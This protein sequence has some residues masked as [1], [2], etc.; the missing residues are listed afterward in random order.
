MVGKGQALFDAEPHFPSD[1][2]IRQAFILHTPMGVNLV[3][4]LQW[5]TP[6]AVVEARGN[7]PRIIQQ[8]LGQD[9][10]PIL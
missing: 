1:G 8:V 7:F 6:Q 4:H 5:M 9:L 3:E 2:N 10:V